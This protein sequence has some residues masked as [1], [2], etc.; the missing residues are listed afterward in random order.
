MSGRTSSR[1]WRDLARVAHDGDD[2]AAD[3]QDDHERADDRDPAQHRRVGA[4]ARRRR[5]SAAR[6]RDRM[7]PERKTLA[8]SISALP[9]LVRSSASAS[10][11]CRSVFSAMVWS[12]SA[13]FSPTTADE[14]PDSM[15][16]VSAYGASARF[17]L[18][19]WSLRLRLRACRRAPD[20]SRCRWRGSRAGS[21]PR[22][23]ARCAARPR[24]SRVSRASIDL[25]EIDLR[26]LAEPDRHAD[27]GEQRQ[28]PDGKQANRGLDDETAGDR[29][30]FSPCPFSGAGTRGRPLVPAPARDAVPASR[31]T[32]P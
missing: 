8:S 27:D 5:R 24:R 9:R 4:A 15:A 10:A 21:I 29:H 32:A 1:A 6:R 30:A 22:S 18:S 11:S 28:E 31:G 12:I 7:M 19:S 17:S 13:I 3:H 25:V 26:A 23:A 2:D 16:S 20:R 14:P